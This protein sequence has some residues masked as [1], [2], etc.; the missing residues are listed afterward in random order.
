MLSSSWKV[1]SLHILLAT[2]KSSSDT[3]KR[4]ARA[5]NSLVGSY[6]I[7]FLRLINHERCVDADQT[8]QW[9]IEDNYQRVIKSILSA[10][11]VRTLEMTLVHTEAEKGATG[12]GTHTNEIDHRTGGFLVRGK[13]RDILTNL[14]LDLS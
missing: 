9:F 7:S 3:V 11:C 10:A 5:S 14:L 12:F 6:V 8:P 13:K 2:R 4:W 1:Q